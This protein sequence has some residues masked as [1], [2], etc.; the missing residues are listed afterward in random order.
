MHADLILLRCDECGQKIAKAHRIYKRHRYCA[1][2]Y[3]RVFKRR[4]C[5]KCGNFSR[6]PESDPAAIC[7]K[8]ENNRPCIRCG[9]VSYAIGKITIYGP[10]CNACS[11]YFRMPEPCEV[12]GVLSSTLTRLSR[13][14]YDRRVCPKCARA[15]YGTCQSCSR[16][17]RLLET[18]DGRMLCKTC[19]EK[20]EVTCPK[21]QEPMPA[22]Y[23]RECRQCYWRGL[24]E[25]R[26]QMD[27]AAFSLPWMAMHFEA[28]SHWLMVLVGVHKAALTI[29]RYLPFFTEVERNWKGFPE[30][31]V[32][33]AHFGTAKL[34]RVLL[35]MRWMEEA[36]L[37]VPDV[38]AKAA[39]SERRRIAVI[40][41]QFAKGMKERTLLEGYYRALMD[42]MNSGKMRLRSVRLALSPAAALLRKAGEIDRIPPN[43]GVLDIYLAKIPGQRAA[44][45]GFVRYLREVHGVKVA[46][47]KANPRR[48]QRQRRKKLEAELLALMKEEGNTKDFKRRWLSASLMYFHGL[49]R[50]I[51]FIVKDT[52]ITQADD[53]IIVVWNNQS[54]WIVTYPK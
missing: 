10:V 38:M 4:I 27:C 28:F 17:R 52:D 32:L 20:G 21:C 25:K 14:G 45:S 42:N 54:Y 11:T 47:P 29:H 15:D 2:C 5:P 46:L 9:K 13:L 48:V 3:A 35:P 31:A 37:V 24:L 30:F 41:E 19:L 16:N 43:Q 34:R 6:L 44:I 8:C 1:I 53:G 18:P 50:K 36:G 51:G 33:L 12:C 39:D 40:L 22:G 23:G 49:R 26:I 7:R